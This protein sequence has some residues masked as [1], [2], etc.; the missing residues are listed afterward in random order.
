MADCLNC[1]INELVRARL[2][3]DNSVDLNDLVT[4][5]IECAAEMIADVA[6][7]EE[8]RDDGRE[9]AGTRDFR[10][11][12]S[13]HDWSRYHK[14]RTPECFAL[15]SG[16]TWIEIRASGNSSLMARSRRSQ[17]S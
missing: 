2:E 5:I 14:T 9:S 13:G 6:P 11:P 17:M 15:S 1:Q 7:A 8:Q 4:K 16:S 3:H 10:E 12:A